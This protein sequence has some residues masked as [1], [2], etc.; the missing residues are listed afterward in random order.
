MNYLKRARELFNDVVDVRREL[1]QHPEVGFELPNTVKTIKNKLDEFGIKYEMLN[2]T[3][4]IVGTLGDPKR[5]KTILLRSDMDALAIEEKSV[6]ECKSKNDN[7]HL[8][9]HD[10]HATTLLLTLKMLKENEENLDGQIHFLFQ[11]AEETLNGGKLMLDEGFL[12][13]FKVDAGLALHMWPNGEELGILIS[14]GPALAS[15]LNFRIT[16]KGIGTHGAM[17][18]TGLILSLLLAK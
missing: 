16:I 1:H 5:G 11:P 18:F 12:E 10:M 7:G 2:D 17:P 3:Y 4:A 9:G 15:A 6:H 14:K 8:C 13:R